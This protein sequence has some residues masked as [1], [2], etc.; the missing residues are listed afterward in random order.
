VLILCPLVTVL[1]VLGILV[2]LSPDL[3]PASCRTTASVTAPAA[4]H[5]VGWSCQKLIPAK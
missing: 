2:G 4:A 1:A 3:V 5:V